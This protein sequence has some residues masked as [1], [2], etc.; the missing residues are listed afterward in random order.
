MTPS[1]TFGVSLGPL[2]LHHHAGGTARQRFG[3]ERVAVE[4][5]PAQR[6][7]DVA[8]RHR[9]AVGHHAADRRLT[10]A[11][12]GAAHR[13]GNPAQRQRN[14]THPTPDVCRRAPSASRATATSSNGKLVPPIT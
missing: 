11:T 9:P 13:P 12:Q 5:R 10:P 1:P 3:G 6:H 2:P 8:G 7:E 4:A 14:R